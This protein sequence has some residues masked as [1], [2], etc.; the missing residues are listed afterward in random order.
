MYKIIT[1]NL[2]PDY[3]F[4]VIPN[5]TSN[6]ISYPNPIIHQ[7]KLQKPVFARDTS[8]SIALDSTFQPISGAYTDS[9]K[10][11]L[12]LNTVLYFKDGD[13][14][15]SIQIVDD[16]YGITTT[17]STVNIKISKQAISIN[18]IAQTYLAAPASGIKADMNVSNMNV[19]TLTIQYPFQCRISQDIQTM[20]EKCV[21]IFFA[22]DYEQKRSYEIGVV[23][24][25]PPINDTSRVIQGN[26]KVPWQSEC[27]DE[28]ERRLWGMS[29]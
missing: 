26:L 4:F 1:H 6:A 10:Y 11:P 23:Q 22:K 12:Y 25:K 2:V 24:L 8:I 18:A 29:P 19:P 15:K 27:N 9:S 17:F 7:V 13:E 16:N 14:Y 20:G 28:T 5:V 3:N 21:Y